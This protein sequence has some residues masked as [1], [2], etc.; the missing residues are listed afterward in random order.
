MGLVLGK[1]SVE[2]PKYTVFA[3]GTDYEIREYGANIVAEVTY[4]PSK[5]NSGG[6][7]ILANYI[8]ALGNPQN[9]K[10]GQKGE[11]IAMTAPVLTA[12]GG[13]PAEKINTTAPSEKIA[14][15]APVLTEE[16]RADDVDQGKKGLMVMQFV[17]PSKYTSVDDVPRPTDSRVRVKEV[18][19]RKYGVLKFSGI[20][21]DKL[22][23]KKVDRLK[24]VLQEAGY[25]VTGQHILAQYNPP[26]TIPFLRTN[27]VMLPVEYCIFFFWSH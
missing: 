4:D 17:L 2:T 27:E 15:T 5:S 12:A 9:V 8:G 7:M 6:F 21:E 13:G 19:S 24:Q 18:S 26:W 23:Q 16:N 10:G 20:A 14:M 11:E 1:I 25:K 3:S 22:V